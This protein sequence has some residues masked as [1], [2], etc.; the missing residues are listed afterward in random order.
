LNKARIELTH[1][2]TQDQQL[3]KSGNNLALVYHRLEDFDTAIQIAE[4]LTVKHPLYATGWN[5]KGAVLLDMGKL[6]AAK[7]DFEKALECNPFLIS[8]IANL[9]NVAYQ[10]KAYDLARKRWME[11][12]MINPDHT[13]SRNGIQHLDSLEQP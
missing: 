8:A 13:H 9:G 10:Q 12:L 6:E 11:V 3:R 4:E 2:W 1:A 5:T 7:S